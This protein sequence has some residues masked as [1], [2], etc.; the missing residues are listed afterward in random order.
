MIVALSSVAGVIIAIFMRPIDGHL[1]LQRDG[2]ALAHLIRTVSYGK[3]L[4][5]FATTTLLV[6]GGFM[7][8]PFGSA[9]TVNNIGIPIE[10]L[11]I[12]YMI[13]GVFTLFAGPL[14]GRFSDTV[15][16]YP[17]F[18]V[19]SALSVVM[20]LIYTHLGITPLWQVVVVNVFLFIGITSRM[21]SASALMSAVPDAASR[22]AFMS[23]NSSLQQ[24]AGGI[25]SAVA[26]LIVVQQ[27]GGSLGRYDTLGYVVITSMMVTVTMMFFINRSVNARLPQASPAARPSA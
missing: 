25:A 15:G 12:I 8:M 27:A 22:G 13:T 6:T 1:K 16:K 3:Y 19:G 18:C 26:G 10:K 17:L 20:I 9:F 23:V 5:A 11:P 24:I 7:L 14:I 4:R 2:S 21:I